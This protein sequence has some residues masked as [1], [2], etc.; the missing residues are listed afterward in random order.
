MD[1]AK[2]IREKAEKWLK[3]NQKKISGAAPE[4]KKKRRGAKRKFKIPAPA[5]DVFPDADVC[6]LLGINRKTLMRIRRANK[7]GT[8]WDCVENHAGMKATWILETNPKAEIE[9][10]AQWAIQPGDGIVSVEVV[11][12]T[13]DI[14]KLVCK[15]LSDNETV[16]VMVRDASDFLDGEQFDAAEL[17]GRYVWKEELNRV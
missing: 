1:I 2:R 10:I 7:R 4:G 11:Q 9:K 3:D 6:R 16:V 8:T 17:G 5:P 12:H 14:N 13:R 15:R